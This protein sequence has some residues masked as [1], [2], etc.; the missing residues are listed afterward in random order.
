MLLIRRHRRFETT[1]Q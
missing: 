1:S